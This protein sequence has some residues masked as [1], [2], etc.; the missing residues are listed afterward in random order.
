MSKDE[1][2][3]VPKP[4]GEHDLGAGHARELTRLHL[5]VLVRMVCNRTWDADGPD[6][7]E[8]SELLPV[9]PHEITFGEI[10]AVL[11]KIGVEPRD[12]F[13]ELSRESTRRR[14]EAEY[15]RLLEA[16]P[17]SPPSGGG[18]GRPPPPDVWPILE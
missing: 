18:S 10:L 13:W 12:Y 16:M 15:L 11:E 1:D 4:A 3:D 9:D 2:E 8:I 17:R 14:V 6:L 5:E 7:A